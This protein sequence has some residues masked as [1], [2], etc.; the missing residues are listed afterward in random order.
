MRRRRHWIRGM[1]GGLL[2]GI[3]LGIASIVYAFNAFG[4]LTPWIMVA[5]GLVI[6]IL[7]VFVPRPWGRRR[8]PEK[9]RT[10]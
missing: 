4:P 2:L 8:P 5:S 10:V 6:G 3:G 1:F 7:L 9:A